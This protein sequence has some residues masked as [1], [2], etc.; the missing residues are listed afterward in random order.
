M[1]QLKQKKNKCASHEVSIKKVYNTRR[2]GVRACESCRDTE[3]KVKTLQN[4]LKELL[5]QNDAL[6]SRVAELEAII[7]ECEDIDKQISFPMNEMINRTI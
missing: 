3:E 7:S 1:S 2:G 4:A 5:D 6:R